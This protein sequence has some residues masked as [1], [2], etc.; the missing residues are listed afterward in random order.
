MTF[1]LLFHFFANQFWFR[2]LVKTLCL[3][4]QY[5]ADLSLIKN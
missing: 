1:N 2:L 3:K 4:T 5:L